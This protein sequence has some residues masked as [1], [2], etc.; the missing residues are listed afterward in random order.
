MLV[1]CVGGNNVSSETGTD[2][3]TDTEGSTASIWGTQTKNED[4]GIQL[5]VMSFNVLY[6]DINTVA[7]NDSSK[8]IYNTVSNRKKQVNAMLLG[9]EID[10]VGFQEIN[11]EWFDNFRWLD[12]RY[13]YVGGMTSSNEGGYI[14]YNKNKL[15]VLLTGKF[16]LAEGAPLVPTKV[17]GAHSDRICSWAI[18]KIKETGDVFV[19]MD[20]HVD[21]LSDAVKV[22]QANVLSEQTSVLQ[23]L[24]NSRYG[25]G[26]NC[27]LILVGD[28]NSYASSDLYKIIT[29]RLNDARKCSLGVTV[30]GKYATLIG[31]NEFKYY[32]SLADVPMNSVVTDHIFVSDTTTVKKF[33]MIHTTTNLCEYGEYMSDHNAVIAEIYFERIGGA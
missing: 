21:Y 28:M 16:W 1:S 7:A 3:D 29:Q 17:D 9:E 27:P 12:E 13:D 15:K 26:E 20:T 5:N 23:E 18:F 4:T 32:T 22:V 2:T 11:Q 8:R 19:F 30:P 10:V 33:K 25:A 6:K 14:V 31:Q 24:A